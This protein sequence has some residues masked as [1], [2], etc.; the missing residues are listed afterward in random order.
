MHSLNINIAVTMPRNKF[1]GI[2][3]CLSMP[4]TEIMTTGWRWRQ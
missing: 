2:I 4:R 1:G 3:R